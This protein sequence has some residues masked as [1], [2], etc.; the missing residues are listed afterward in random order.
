KTTTARLRRTRSPSASSVPSPVPSRAQQPVP[1]GAFDPP[2]LQPSARTSVA[3]SPPPRR[4]APAQSAASAH[5]NH[6]HSRQDSRRYPT[7]DSPVIRV[8]GFDRPSSRDLCANSHNS[9]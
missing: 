9:L 6:A 8:A 2:T 5:E 7:S 4:V 1:H 3:T